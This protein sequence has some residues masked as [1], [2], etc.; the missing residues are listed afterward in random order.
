MG[1]LLL[2][3]REFHD[4]GDKV[5]IVLYERGRGPGSGIVVDDQFAHVWSIDGSKVTRIEVFSH[6][7]MRSRRRRAAR[8]RRSSAP[9]SPG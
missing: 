8:A 9:P 4:A 6:G 7:A 3:P 1:E 5:V 2:E